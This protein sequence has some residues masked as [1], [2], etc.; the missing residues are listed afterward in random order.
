MAVLLAQSVIF[1]QDN[2]FW[3][4]TSKVTS[5]AT[6]LVATSGAIPFWPKL[7]EQ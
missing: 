6:A 2:G 1:F 5:S 4:I 3:P 7:E